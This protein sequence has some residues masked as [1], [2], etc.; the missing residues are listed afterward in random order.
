MSKMRTTICK[1]Q[2]LRMRY[3][4]ALTLN[5]TGHI[6]KMRI[7]IIIGIAS[8]LVISCVQPEKHIE[9]TQ[10]INYESLP[11]IN[12]NDSIRIVF[13]SNKSY[14]LSHEPLLFEVEVLGVESDSGYLTVNGKEFKSEN[15]KF[16]GSMRGW[17]ASGEK[18]LLLE[19]LSNEREVLSRLKVKC[20]VVRPEGYIYSEY[21]KEVYRGIENKLDIHCVDRYRMP[22]IKSF[23]GKI[24]AKGKDIYTVVPED[25]AAVVRIELRCGRKNIIVEEFS[26]KEFSTP[27]I[28]IQEDNTGYELVPLLKLPGQKNIKCEFIELNGIEI[29]DGQIKNRRWTNSKV[30][31]EKG[32]TIYF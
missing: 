7:N 6:I 28:S 21:G 9:P 2:Y 18:K 15:N 13:K 11:L 26:I 19:Y 8:L 5:V 22:D 17:S 20:L 1:R 3:G 29:I 10:E 4:T 31:I 27:I 14:Y 25:T 12:E 24:R 23:G 16:I 30:R 32:R